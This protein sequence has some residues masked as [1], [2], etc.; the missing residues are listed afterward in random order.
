MVGFIFQR[1]DEPV[2]KVQTT[3][4]PEIRLQSDFKN[5]IIMLEANKD[6]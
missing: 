3:E 2:C 4:E 5:N 6:A 1:R